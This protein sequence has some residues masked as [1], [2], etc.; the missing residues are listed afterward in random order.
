M[1]LLL[2]LLIQLHAVIL[3]QFRIDSTF[4]FILGLLEDKWMM[5]LMIT[6]S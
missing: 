2:N 5:L 1:L 3:K 4:K 6:N